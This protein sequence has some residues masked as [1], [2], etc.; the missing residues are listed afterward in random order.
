MEKTTTSEGKSCLGCLGMVGIIVLVGYI[1]Y[2][3]TGG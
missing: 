1:V 2:K 3:G